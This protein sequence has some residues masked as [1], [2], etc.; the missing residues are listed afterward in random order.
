MPQ[1]RV[2][3]VMRGNRRPSR[4][5]TPHSPRSTGPALLGAREVVAATR[6]GWD[7]SAAK[8]AAAEGDL[9]RGM[10]LRARPDP[11]EGGVSW[12][13]I[14]RAWA[15]AASVEGASVM[16]IMGAIKPAGRGRGNSECHGTSASAALPSAMIV[17][18]ISK[19][20]HDAKRSV[21]FD[22]AKVRRVSIL[23]RLDDT[24]PNG[25]GAGEIFVQLIT[26]AHPNGAL[27]HE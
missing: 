11:A 10:R 19:G 7:R 20:R 14:P 1:P 26:V 21:L 15:T 13:V 2:D 27:E 5:R 25:P 22:T 17:T 18:L 6:V 3:E 4:A 12:L 16:G 9:R 24:T 8:R 23:P